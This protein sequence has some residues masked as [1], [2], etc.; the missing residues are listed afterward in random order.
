MEDKK[1]NKRKFP[2]RCAQ[3]LPILSGTLAAMLTEGKTVKEI[4]TLACFLNSLS[5]DLFMIACVKSKSDVFIDDD[6][7]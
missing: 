6:F 3:S 7:I 4:E 2:K 5:N 1:C